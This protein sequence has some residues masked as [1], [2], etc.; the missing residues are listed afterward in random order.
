MILTI[1]WIVEVVFHLFFLIRD[2]TKTATRESK[3]RV[4]IPINKGPPCENISNIILIFKE[5][6]SSPG[7]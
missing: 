4:R 5:M 2:S 3:I 1:E 6:Y 7:L